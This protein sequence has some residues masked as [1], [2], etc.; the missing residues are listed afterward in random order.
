MVLDEVLKED[1][2]MN[3][4]TEEQQE[5]VV[6]AYTAGYI[7]ALESYIDSIDEAHA[8]LPKE[9]IDEIKRRAKERLDK[10]RTALRKTKEIPGLKNSAVEDVRRK[11]NHAYKQVANVNNRISQMNKRNP[12]TA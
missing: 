5:Y 10:A 9:A 4:L 6:D 7:A 8:N 11:F 1:S 2:I 3:S 12:V